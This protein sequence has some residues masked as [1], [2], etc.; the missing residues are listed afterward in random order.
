MAVAV[1]NP[2]GLF[3]ALEVVPC[4]EP[5]STSDVASPADLA[6]LPDLAS[7][8]L[9]IMRGY[10]AHAGTVHLLDSFGL[11][12]LVASQGVPESVC[13]KMRTL[14]L[15]KGAAG[16]ATE[17]RQ[18]VNVSNLRMDPA[19]EGRPERETAGLKQALALPIFRGDAVIGALGIETSN[20][21]AFSDVEIAALLDAGRSIGTR[22]L[23]PLRSGGR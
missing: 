12:H 9:Q 21:R 19:G 20:D 16:L 6:S 23:G 15:G 1:Q 13:D 11:L 5:S 10:S 7:A 18:A 17:R 4:S 22:F 14:P 2:A 3:P 8:L